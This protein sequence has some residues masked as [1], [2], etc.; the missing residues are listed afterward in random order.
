MCLVPVTMTNTESKTESII[1]SYIIKKLVQ[2]YMSSV[3]I[4]ISNKLL[5]VNAILFMLK[6]KVR[7]NIIQIQF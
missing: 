1:N 5:D 3:N 2:F 6:T 7:V 4:F